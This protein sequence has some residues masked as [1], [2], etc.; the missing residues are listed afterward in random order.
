MFPA[1]GRAAVR[2]IAWSRTM[3]RLFGTVVLRYRFPGAASA[4]P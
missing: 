1:S 2:M 3:S 4:R